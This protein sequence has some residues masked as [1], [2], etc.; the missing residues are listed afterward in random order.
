MPALS[1]VPTVVIRCVYQPF[2]EWLKV[3]L[4]IAITL[5]PERIS[6]ILPRL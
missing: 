4:S 6:L 1:M 2:L 5:L 3:R